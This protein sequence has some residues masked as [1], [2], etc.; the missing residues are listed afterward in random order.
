MRRASAYRTLPLVAKNLVKSSGGFTAAVIVRAVFQWLLVVVLAKLGGPAEVGAFSALLAVASP[1]IIF[2][3]FGYRNVYASQTTV[4]NAWVAIISRI[5]LLV[6]ASAVI[7]T[8]GSLYGG[9]EIELL[10]AISCTKALES[11]LDLT[12][13]ADQRIG[14][15]RYPA[16]AIAVNA[17]LGFAAFASARLWGAGLAGS[18]LAMGAP[19]LIILLVSSV[20]FRK[21]LQNSKDLESN[22]VGFQWLVRSGFPTGLAQSI[23][24]LSAYLPI[25]ALTAGGHIQEAGQ[26]AVLSYFLVIA[27]LIMGSMQQVRLSDA[28][29]SAS[30]PL[31]VFRK[32]CTENALIALPISVLTLFAVKFA[33]G[34]VYGE[35]FQGG[36]LSAALV[37]ASI[38]F[39]PVSY[40]TATAMLILGLFNRQLMVTFGTL[41][42][43]AV[44]LVSFFFL[45]PLTSALTIMVMTVGARAVFGYISII[46][47]ATR[48]ERRHRGSQLLFD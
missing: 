29:K 11:I 24:S 35:A 2:F 9:I 3:E 30:L 41:A 15:M 13:L 16:I 47:R 45:S 22:E 46:S 43:G 4:P 23:S 7:V 34:P 32:A 48:L 8:V 26:Y 12:F 36:W 38:V 21:K 28:R 44:G 14:R 17:C 39:L 27:Q 18:I 25:F 6:L 40:G 20:S 33:L 31:T 1:T 42:V 19:T 5:L 10:L 37:A